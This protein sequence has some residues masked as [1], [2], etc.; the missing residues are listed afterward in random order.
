VTLTVEPALLVGRQEPTFAWIPPYTSTLGVE[1]VE[2]AASAGLILDPWQ[3]L[4]VHV[5]A[6]EDRRYCPVCFEVGLVLSRQNGKDAGIEA[7]ELGW[8][9]LLDVQMIIHS[10]HL[11]DTSKEHFLRILHLIDNHDDFRRRV[12]AVR[13][14]KGDEQIELLSGQRLDFMTRKGGAGR[15]F[16]AEKLVLNEAMYLDAMMMAAVL[17]T[18]ATRPGA[19]VI[20]AG[21]AGMRHSTQLALVRR[22][23]LA[24]NEPSLGYLEWAADEEDDRADPQTW[25]KTNPGLGRRIS[26]EY[27][28]R[29]ML[30][31]G[32]PDSAA[33]ATE[34][35]G[36][37]DWPPDENAW[38]AIGRAEWEAAA[39]VPDAAVPPVSF[40]VEVEWDRSAAA[41][42]V[43][44][45]RPDGLRQIE[46]TATDQV[47][48][49]HPGTGWVVARLK[50]L[51]ERHQ[52]SQ[53]WIDP[54]GPAGS[55]VKDLDDAEVRYQKMSL[56][57][58]GRAY[59]QMFDG[60]AG[61]DPAVRNLRHGNQA[62]LNQAVERAVERKI[63][64]ARAFDRKLSGAFAPLGAVTAALWGV[65]PDY[66]VL[67]SVF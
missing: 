56:T 2:Q 22:R 62:A 1:V 46:L 29:E 57:D 59:G 55:L 23:A 27:V 25:A 20:Y 19:Q 17:P 39:D 9:F 31:M 42:G 8:L 63:G 65:P 12:K 34:R 11:F 3:E 35:L 60:I 66:D 47:V 7:V 16:T 37:G 58:A 64:D 32:G 54:A 40:G 44:W 5:V 24:R 6:A 38:Q 41:I 36:I 52:P 49:H 53:L 21:S 45:R 43:A 30:A 14:G 13:K 67:S 15:G 18:L 4:F 10:A 28:R 61:P 48:D 51:L 50:E 26:V 33:F